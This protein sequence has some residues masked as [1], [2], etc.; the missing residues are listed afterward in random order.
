MRLLTA[1]KRSVWYRQPKREH[2]TKRD[3]CPSFPLRGGNAL[4]GFGAGSFLTDAVE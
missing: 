4:L 1:K 2:G 3:D